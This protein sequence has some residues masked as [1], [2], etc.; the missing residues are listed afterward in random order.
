[1]LKGIADNNLAEKTLEID[2]QFCASVFLVAGGYPADYE[3]GKTINGIEEVKNSLVFH[4]GTKWT[5]D[6]SN[7]ITNG[8]RVLT[9]TS[10]G[11]SLDE[12]LLK[13]YEDVKSI[14]FQGMYCR[15]DIGFDLK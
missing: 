2:Q 7:V 1:L 6:H 4:A 5:G 9:V 13:A 15:K 14:N 8:G 11:N 3:K 10:F 12:A